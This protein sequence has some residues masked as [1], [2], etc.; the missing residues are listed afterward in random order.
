MKGQGL[1]GLKRKEDGDDD[2]ET[3]H[4]AMSMPK[5][6]ARS[7]TGFKNDAADDMLFGV[8]KR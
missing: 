6:S 3:H 5:F 2:D 4:D 8:E 7:R 1:E